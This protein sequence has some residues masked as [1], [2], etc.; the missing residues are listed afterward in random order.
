MIKK[1]ILL[2]LI[3]AP[4]AYADKVDLIIYKEIFNPGETVQL[5][6][7]LNENPVYKPEINILKFLDSSGSEIKIAP[8]ISRIKDD[9]FFYSFVLPE[10]K[11]GPY[12]LSLSNLKYVVNN[13]LKEFSFSKN[14][15]IDDKGKAAVFQPAFFVVGDSLEIKVESSKGA[16]NLTVLSSDGITHPY[17]RPQFINEG[18]S[19]FFSFEITNDSKPN[20]FIN[21]TFDGGFFYVPI[22]NKKIVVAPEEKII[23]TQPF[24]FS[25]KEIV[26]NLGKSGSLEGQIEIIS[27]IDEP[28]RVNF[29]VPE[30][31]KNLVKLNETSVLVPPK[32]I[33]EQYIWIN[34]QRAEYSGI[35]SGE[36]KMTAKD[37]AYFMKVQLE[38]EK[39]ELTPSELITPGEDN[40]SVE[41]APA[42]FEEFTFLP[43]ATYT[44]PPKKP[45]KTPLIL[46]IL[47]LII[48]YL[49]YIFSKKKTKKQSFDEY[50]E[51][52]AKK[53]N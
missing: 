9:L 25:P 27:L 43:N 10:I 34:K 38:F 19:R 47:V 3:L 37:Y 50:L 18:R 35:F 20:Y 44:E 29:E 21:F 12:I 15:S 26:K 48:L 24:D 11:D 39:E 6:V 5:V 40:R 17:G 7:N 45:S 4:F 42:G 1:L 41:K 30:E 49:L 13:T 16:M 36:I 31:L 23:Q 51:N 52:M 8:F 2:I 33:Y 32:D 53:R 22:F 14:I 28:L 46:V